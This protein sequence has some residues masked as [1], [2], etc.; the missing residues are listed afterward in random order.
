MKPPTARQAEC[1]A[2]LRDGHARGCPP[3]IREIARKMGTR[4]TNAVVDLLRALERRG[5]VEHH[6]GRYGTGRARMSWAPTGD[7]LGPR[8]LALADEAERS[9]SVIASSVA[10]ILRECAARLTRD[11]DG[12]APAVERD[13]LV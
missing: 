6:P 12:E 10:D 13:A 5:L 7:N 8:L 11:G 9:G 4:S 1:L 2:I 3:T